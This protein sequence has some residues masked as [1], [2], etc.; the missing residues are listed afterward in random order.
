MC[1]D[2]PPQVGRY[3]SKVPNLDMRDWNSGLYKAFVIGSANWSW[4]LTWTRLMKPVWTCSLIKWQSISMCF[5]S[6]L[7][8]GFLTSC[9]TDLLS[10][11]TTLDCKGI[12]KDRSSCLSHK[13]SKVSVAKA[14]Y[15]TSLDEWATVGYFLDFHAMSD[16]SRNTQ[17]LV[18]EQRVTWQLPQSASTYVETR[19][20]DD[21]GNRM[22]WPGEDFRYYN[23]W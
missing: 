15:S 18:V 22:P 12:S 7:H 19:M 14:L 1:V 23:R 13:S 10:Q 17:K 16:E 11:K 2:T 5:E 8:E 21:K 20:D 3:M 9:I 6:S 4:D